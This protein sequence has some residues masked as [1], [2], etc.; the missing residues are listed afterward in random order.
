MYKYLASPYSD[1]EPEVMVQRFRD[2]M[3]AAHWCL[4]HDMIVFSPIVHC[5]Q[6]AVRYGLPRDYDF[7]QKYN[8]AMIGASGG[9]LVLLIDGW[10]DSKGVRSEV[11]LA[12]NRGKPVQH[13]IPTK[14]GYAVAVP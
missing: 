3:Q 12:F 5:H 7:W 11:D 4:T 2:T 6:M 1:P 10:F 9:I 14:D 8:E 13:L